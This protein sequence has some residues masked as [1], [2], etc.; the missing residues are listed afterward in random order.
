MMLAGIY[1][2]KKP[3]TVYPLEP[4]IEFV[5]CHIEKEGSGQDAFYTY[6]LTFN[7]TD[8]D[9]DLGLNENHNDSPFHYGSVYYHNLHAD[10][11]EKVGGNFRKVV[12]PPIV[13]DTIQL[14]GRFPVLTPEGNAKAIKGTVIARLTLGYWEPASDRSNITKLKVWVNDRAL[15]HSNV[16]ETPEIVLN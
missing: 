2:C 1:G 5:D 6:V 4:Q 8:G 16:I 11:F 7:F 3:V 13:G 14:T 10:Y 9:G 12:S 15:N